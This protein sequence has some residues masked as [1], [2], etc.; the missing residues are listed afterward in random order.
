MARLKNAKRIHEIAAFDPL[1][2]DTEPTEWLRLAKYIETIDDETD[3][4]TDDT[5]Y[6]DG[7]GTPEETVLSV[8]GG[9]SFEGLYDA[10]DPAQALIAGMKY[11]TGD[12][13]RVWHRVTSADGKKRY[14]QIANASEIKAGAGDATEYEQFACTLKWI[15]EPKE[16]AVSGL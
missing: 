6:Y 14:T 15:K 7:D 16:T 11:K 10:E 9:Y 4:D 1:K 8:V 12:A 13:R 3:E 2:G 5:G